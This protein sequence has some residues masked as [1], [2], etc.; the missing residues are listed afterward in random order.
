MSDSLIT[1]K[2]MAESIKEMMKKKSLEKITVSDIVQ[3]CGLN[4]QTFYYHF[5]DKYDLVNWI[6]NNEL[7]SIISSVSDDTDWSVVMLN[8]LD[9][10]RKEKVFYIGSLNLDRQNIFHDFLFNATRDM[11]LEIIRQQNVRENLE[12]D[13]SDCAF[14]AEFYTYGLVG[15]VI[16]W[17]T[18]GMKETPEEIVGRLMHLID[19]SKRVFATRGRKKEAAPGAEFSNA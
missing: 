16:Q 17:A 3:N 6:Y 11:L 2:A 18:K 13:D 10:M 14:V 8:V 4:R 19:D 1:K 5:R 15:M 12:I 9:V 7:V